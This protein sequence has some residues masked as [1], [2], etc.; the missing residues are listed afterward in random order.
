M[1]SLKEIPTLA[2]V[3]QLQLKKNSQLHSTKYYVVVERES[4][5]DSHNA[6]RETASTLYG[7]LDFLR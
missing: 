7:T 2:L 6:A 4:I 3:I 1:H 5:L